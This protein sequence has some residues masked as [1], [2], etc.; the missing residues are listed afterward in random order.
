[1]A[2]LWRVPGV[3]AAL[4]LSA[5]VS[6]S[7]GLR[8][9]TGRYGMRINLTNSLRILGAA[10]GSALPVLPVVYYSPL[11]SFVNVLLGG[12]VYLAASLTLLPL[13][14]AIKQS[15]IQA[16]API[17]SPI[18]IIRPITNLIFAYETRLVKAVEGG[19]G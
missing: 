3:I 10:L 11:P 12:F 19:F 1:M 15:D 7:F 4:I 13:F 14:R 17:L 5:L 2:S 9:A 8:I 6:T 18:R 16:L